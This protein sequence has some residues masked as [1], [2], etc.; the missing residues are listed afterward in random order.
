MKNFK[1]FKGYYDLTPEPEIISQNEYNRRRDLMA[2]EQ[3]RTK[4]Y[5][6]MR[7]L[8]DLLEENRFYTRKRLKFNPQFCTNIK[9]FLYSILSSWKKIK[10]ILFLIT[11]TSCNPQ[12]HIIGV[13]M[14]HHNLSQN[15]KQP[16]KQRK[17]VRINNRI[18]F[19][20]F[21]SL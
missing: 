10:I 6:Q 3:Y 19:F 14:R 18:P 1:I 20:I 9:I 17:P 5:E 16:N 15:K 21:Q 7:I 4:Y 2:E 13:G 11:I 8:D 12:M